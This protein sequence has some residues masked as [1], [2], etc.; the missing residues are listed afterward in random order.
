MPVQLTLQPKADHLRF[1]ITGTRIEG[2]FGVEMLGIWQ[3]VADECKARGLSRVLG[4][5][6]V[7]GHV[8][9]VELFEVGEKTPPML[10]RAGCKKVAYVVLGDRES[11]SALKFGEDVAVNRGLTTK[12]FSDES[13]ALVWLMQP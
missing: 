13:S 7:T 8:P 10:A 9:V 1:E 5:S 12:V 6:K 2:E 4:I 11:L 3:L